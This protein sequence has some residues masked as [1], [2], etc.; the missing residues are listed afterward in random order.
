MHRGDYQKEISALLLAGSETDDR[1]PFLFRPD[2]F[3][4][5]RVYFL[6]IISHCLGCRVATVGRALSSFGSSSAD[7]FLH[8]RRCEYVE[9]TMTIIQTVEM[10]SPQVGHFSGSKHLISATPRLITQPRCFC[11]LSFGLWH[12][13][14]ARKIRARKKTDLRFDYRC[15]DPARQD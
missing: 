4:G 3:D 7:G 6:V 5:F 8:G 15:E 12:P 13:Q 11:R 9:I 10:P 2:G 1:C 14:L